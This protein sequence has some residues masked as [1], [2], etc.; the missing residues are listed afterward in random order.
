MVVKIIKR[1]VHYI[2]LIR[3]PSVRSLSRRSSAYVQP[4]ANE[5]YEIDMTAPLLPEEFSV[6]ISVIT[7]T[8]GR[9]TLRRTGTSV[10]SQLREQDEWI[11]VGDG[12]QPAAEQICSTFNDKRITCRQ[13]AGTRVWGNK[14]RDIGIGLARG[15]RLVFVDDDDELSAVALDTVR[16]AHVAYPASPLVFRMNVIDHGKVYWDHPEISPSNVGTPMFSPLHAGNLPKW[17]DGS[18]HGYASDY[19]FIRECCARQGSPVFLRNVICIVHHALALP[20]MWR[21]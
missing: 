6:K 17:S 19:I 20:L 15:Q 10:V 8:V 14:E 9:D 12:S 2:P 18:G 5:S 16:R 3:S 13:S 7:P 11:V 21:R 4:C 1:R